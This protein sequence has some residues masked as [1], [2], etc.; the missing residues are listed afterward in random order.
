MFVSVGRNAIP[1][2][3]ESEDFFRI[4]QIII[5]SKK[6][7]T[8]AYPIVYSK[9]FTNLS[10]NILVL[11]KILQHK[12]CHEIPQNRI[13]IEDNFYRSCLFNLLRSFTHLRVVTGRTP[14]EFL[15]AKPSPRSLAAFSLVCSS[16]FHLIFSRAAW[17]KISLTVKRYTRMRIRQWQSFS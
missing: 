17:N 5:T 14:A 15:L 2:R 7:K 6:K 1:F 9:N 8:W 10:L 11:I 12:E 13:I 4:I 3:G 16:S